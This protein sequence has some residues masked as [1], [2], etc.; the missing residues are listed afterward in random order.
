MKAPVNE[1]LV[2]DI[3][4]R[5]AVVVTELTA[6]AD[7]LKQ[8]GFARQ[9]DRWERAI[10]DDHDRQA[11]VAALIDLDALFSAGRD[12]SPAGTR[13]V[14]PGDRC[15]SKWLPFGCMARAVAIRGRT[16]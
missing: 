16:T 9:S 11:L 10:A 15:R 5:V 14:L 3:A 6:A 13:R 4:G 7:V 1:M 12:W 8:L 2:T